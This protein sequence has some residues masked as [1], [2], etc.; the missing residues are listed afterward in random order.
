MKYLFLSLIFLVA[1]QGNNGSNGRSPNVVKIM[2]GDTR[3]GG[4]GG[5]LVDSLVICNGSNGLDGKNGE[6]GANAVLEAFVICP[7]DTATYPEYAFRID[8]EIYAVY[9]DK[10]RAFLAR[11]L[12]GTYVT[13]NGSNCKFTVDDGGN[14]ER[15]D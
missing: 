6:D 7:G 13:T 11:V 15:V 2:P 5:I 9:Y 12:P 14:I 3:C 4:L 1:C 10:D 8:N